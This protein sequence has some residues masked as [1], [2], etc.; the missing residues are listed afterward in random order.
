MQSLTDLVAAELAEPVD[1]RVSAMAEAIAARHGAASRAVLFYGSCLREKQLDG[2]ML[3]FYLIVSDYRAAYDRRWLATANRLIPP[4]VFP[5][6]HDGLAAKYAV[7]SE[8]DFHRLCG[9]ET[10]N[11][12]VWARFAQPSRLV[13]SADAA[14][15]GAAARAVARAAPTL[16]A[17]AGKV[18]GEAPLD[19]WR[20]AFALTYS[21]ELRAERKG[22]SQ[23]VVDADPDRYRRFSEPAIAA[24]P[25]SA[26][27]G[28][29]ARRRIEG[30]ALSV[31]RLAKASATY[32]G[33]AEYIAWKINR[34]AGTNITLKPWQRRHPL[35]AAISL[36]PRLVRS[37]AIR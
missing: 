36:L 18:T 19:W 22:R 13:W 6:Q 24:I 33:G 27:G 2:L 10:R 11:V 16:L 23:S 35:L 4:N 26:I 8:S 14:A 3:D 25:A 15:R 12:S 5:F 21:S 28:G 7:L 34:H 20:R 37:G 9:P 32:A 17:A 29:W 31:L 30:K 1:A